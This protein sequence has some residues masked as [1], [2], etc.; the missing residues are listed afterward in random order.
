MV[1]FFSM[2]ASITGSAASVAGDGP[3]SP[4]IHTL[5][6]R[7][8]DSFAPNAVSLVRLLR[9]R[10]KESAIFL[11]WIGLI[12]NVYDRCLWLNEAAQ[13]FDGAAPWLS[14]LAWNNWRRLLV[15]W[16]TIALGICSFTADIFKAGPFCIGGNSPKDCAS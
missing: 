4:T 15:E 16:A 6:T 2:I 5:P 14:C 10:K 3:G 1:T 11:L 12:T 13:S 9:D 7:L 8:V